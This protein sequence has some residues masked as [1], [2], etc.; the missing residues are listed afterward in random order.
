MLLL[1][2]VFSVV[3]VK[4]AQGYPVGLHRLAVAS[5]VKLW[6]LASMISRDVT[7]V[8][9]RSYGH[10]G[11]CTQSSVLVVIGKGGVGKSTVS[12]TPA[13]LAARNGLSV[14]LVELEGRGGPSAAV[15][16]RALGQVAGSVSEVHARRVGSGG[17]RPDFV[18]GQ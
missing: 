11:F 9:M 6:Q 13:R 4:S 1:V 8:A 17:G 18:A 14:L 12:A 3:S 16:H 7:P 10:L 15:G 2:E 5:R